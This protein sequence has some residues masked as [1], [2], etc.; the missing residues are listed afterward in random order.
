MLLLQ[1]LDQRLEELLLSLHL[2]DLGLHFER[3]AL[4]HA[5]LVHLITT[6]LRKELH[7]P[8]RSE[9]KTALVE[10]ITELRGAALLHGILGIILPGAEE[11]LYLI[12][13]APLIDPSQ[14]NL[15]IAIAL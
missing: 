4:L 11:F 14:D 9:Q 2:L 1:F 8:H 7:V 3:D 5:P 10:T 6:Y 12:C 13:V 15:L